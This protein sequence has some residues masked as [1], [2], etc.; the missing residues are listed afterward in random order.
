M[1]P[2]CV[3]I[4]GKAAPGYFLAKQ[5]VKLINN[6]SDVINNDPKANDFLKL[7]FFP[8]YCVSAMEVICP[9]TEFRHRQHEIHDERSDHDRHT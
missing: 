4:G 1:V 2:R 3:L 5:I 6:V 8:N 9:G 7:V